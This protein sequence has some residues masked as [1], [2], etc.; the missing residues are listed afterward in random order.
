MTPDGAI[1]MSAMQ[2][3]ETWPGVTYSVAAAMIQEGLFDEAFRTAQG[4]YEAAWSQ[5]GL[6]SVSTTIHTLFFASKYF[7]LQLGLLFAFQ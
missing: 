7:G 1:D 3:R 5:E 4:I 2:S 6:G